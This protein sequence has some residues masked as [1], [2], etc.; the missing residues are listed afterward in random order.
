MQQTTTKNVTFYFKTNKTKLSSTVDIKDD[1][2]VYLYDASN[3]SYPRFTIY[4]VDAP[5]INKARMNGIFAV[6]VVPLGK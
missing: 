3:Q 4:I 6:F 5:S 2:F 1:V